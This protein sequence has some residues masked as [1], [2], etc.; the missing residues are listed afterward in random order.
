[1]RIERIEPFLEY[2]EKI[3]QRTLRVVEAI[4]HDRFEWTCRPGEFTL[5]DLVRHVA[6]VERYMYAETVQGKPSRYT[7]HGRDLADGAEAIRDFFDR[8]HRESVEIFARLTPEDLTGKC[9]TPAG[10]PITIWKWLRALV[11]HEI[12]HRGQIYVYL[13]ILGV[14]TPPLYGLTSEEAASRGQE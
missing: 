13:G 11:E 5:G 4:P 12:H 14:K 8:L 7:G 6:V 1:M 3:R 10:F 9:I 2:Y